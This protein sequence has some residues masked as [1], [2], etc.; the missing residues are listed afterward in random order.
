[1]YKIKYYSTNKI[2]SSFAVLSLIISS[3]SI[4]GSVSISEARQH[5][6]VSN[7]NF[8]DEEDESTFSQSATSSNFRTQNRQEEGL[9]ELAIRFRNAATRLRILEEERAAIAER[10]LVSIQGSVFNLNLRDVLS[11]SLAFMIEEFSETKAYHG[12]LG[13][14]DTEEVNAAIDAITAKTLGRMIDTPPSFL[15]R[16]GFG[17]KLEIDSETQ[18]K[19]LSAL[20]ENIKRLLL[21][22]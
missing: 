21:P 1:M 9:L 22:H 14:R 16:L 10:A 17:R 20:G 3:V 6:P 11:K 15:Q 5:T 19:L 7:F 12:S 8:E 13:S 18:T 4:L 2:I